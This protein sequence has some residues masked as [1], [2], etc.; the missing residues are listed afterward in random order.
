MGKGSLYGLVCLIHSVPFFQRSA[1]DLEASARHIERTPKDAP[2]CA[3]VSPGNMLCWVVVCWLTCFVSS[4]ASL[5]GAFVA[6]S[7]SAIV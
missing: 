1:R 4:R 6:N 2:V 5:S 7:G 3:G